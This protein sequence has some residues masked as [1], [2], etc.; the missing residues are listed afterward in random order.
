MRVERGVFYGDVPDSVD[1]DYTARVT[2]LNAA[3]L[4][5]LAWAPPPPDSAI[6]SGAVQPS[7]TLRWKP[8][9]APDLAG[10]KV[11]WR[12]TTSSTWDHWR[13][14][15]DRTAAVLTDLVVDNAFFGIAAVNTA[16]DESPVVFPAP[17]R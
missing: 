6:V 12:S 13:W 1:F 17:G 9:S 14:V 7:T 4:A 11:Y 2:A 15:G 8:A 16:G 10:Y 5:A 3:T